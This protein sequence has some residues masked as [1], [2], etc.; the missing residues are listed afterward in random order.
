MIG[1]D[2]GIRL[3]CVM[4]NGRNEGHAKFNNMK[5]DLIENHIS[6][7][8]VFFPIFINKGT[9]VTIGQTEMSRSTS[10]TFITTHV[11][12]YYIFL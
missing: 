1:N 3:H 6:P 8:I 9:Y 11:I 7:D 10:N 4:F 12:I 2:V 5:Y